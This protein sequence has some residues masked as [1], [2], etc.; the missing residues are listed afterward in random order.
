MGF[1]IKE[2]IQLLGYPHGYG[3]P[4][5]MIH[6]DYEH[7]EEHGNLTWVD[8]WPPSHDSA[9]FRAG[10]PAKLDRT[11]SG[12]LDGGMPGQFNDT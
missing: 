4:I 7:L 6:N 8:T 11:T 10:C 3:N 5:S 2:T 9:H 1:S 12:K